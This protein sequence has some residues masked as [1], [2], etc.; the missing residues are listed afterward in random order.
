MSESTETNLPHQRYVM[1]LGHLSVFLTAHP[2]I[3]ADVMAYEHDHTS[4]SSSSLNFYARDDDAAADIIELFELELG[5]IQF[6]ATSYDEAADLPPVLGFDG[7]R[8]H[9]PKRTEPVSPR[10]LIR[11]GE[12]EDALIREREEAYL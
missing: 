2:E 3:R 11:S 8:I 10:T 6:V 1:A 4:S 12:T 9:L 5:S 7:V